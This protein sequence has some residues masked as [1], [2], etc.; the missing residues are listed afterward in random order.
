MLIVYKSLFTLNYY[1]YI[2]V[3]NYFILVDKLKNV[4]S[5]AVAAEEREP[6]SEHV[7]SS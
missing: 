7:N 5:A 2:T 1:T 4:K 3:E 6:S